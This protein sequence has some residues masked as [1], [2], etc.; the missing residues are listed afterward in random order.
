MLEPAIA[1]AERDTAAL[2]PTP[3]TQE[4]DVQAA[5]FIEVGQ[6]EP[7]PR[8]RALKPARGGLR[9]GAVPPAETSDQTNPGLTCREIEI[10][11][12][13]VEPAISVEVPEAMCAWTRARRA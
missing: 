8:Q 3:L 6:P 9:E 5:I 1:S 7:A 2:W 10:R 13:E 12:D 11:E 4:Q